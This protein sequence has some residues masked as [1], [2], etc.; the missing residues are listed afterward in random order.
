M[1]S[2]QSRSCSHDLVEF[3]TAIVDKVAVFSGAEE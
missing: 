1:K 2:G 3:G